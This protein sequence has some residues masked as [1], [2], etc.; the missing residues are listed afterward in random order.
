MNNALEAAKPCLFLD[1]GGSV[2]VS[3]LMQITF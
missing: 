1:V 2:D 3:R